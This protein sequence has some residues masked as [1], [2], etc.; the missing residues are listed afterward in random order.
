MYP[1]FMNA[2]SDYQSSNMNV[3]APPLPDKHFTSRPR[4][5]RTT[6]G[7]QHVMCGQL[8]DLVDARG[9][10]LDLQLAGHGS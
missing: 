4:Q 1:N 10:E 8:T 7:T 2:L 9:I 3:T 6:A 5:S